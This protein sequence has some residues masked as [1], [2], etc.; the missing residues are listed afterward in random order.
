MTQENYERELGRIGAT[1]EQLHEGQKVLFG[2]IDGLSECLQDLRM[3]GCSVGKK[4][5]EQIKA[6]EDRPHKLMASLS[7]VASIVSLVGAAIAYMFSH[8]GK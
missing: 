4:Q 7:A 3:N 1:L 5:T 6:L 2:K 8:G